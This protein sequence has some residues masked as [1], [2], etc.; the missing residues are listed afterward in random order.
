[1][2][3]SVRLARNRRNGPSRRNAGGDALCCPDGHAVRGLSTPKASLTEDNRTGGLT[4]GVSPFFAV[5]TG[6]IV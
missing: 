3:G 1:M 6:E 5:Q 4:R 2:F